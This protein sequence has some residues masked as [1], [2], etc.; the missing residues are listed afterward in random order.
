[1][2]PP[3]VFD[4]AVSVLSQHQLFI[5][6]ISDMLQRDPEYLTYHFQTS[7]M[8]I[9]SILALKRLRLPS[10]VPQQAEVERLVRAAIDRSAKLKKGTG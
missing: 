1:M 5:S 2:I 9:V 10:T 4:S 8:W 6:D 7:W 3:D